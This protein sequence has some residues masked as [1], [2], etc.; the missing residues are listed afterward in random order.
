MPSKRIVAF[1]AIASLVVAGALLVVLDLGGGKNAVAAPAAATPK[2]KLP[3]RT[4]AVPAPSGGTRAE[5]VKAVKPGAVTKAST[6]EPARLPDDVTVEVVG[7]KSK[8]VK[9]VGPGESTSPAIVLDVKIANGSSAD[10]TVDSAIVALTYGKRADVG[11]PLTGGS[12][13]FTGTIKPGASARGTY[14]FG[15]PTAQQKS[16]Q[17]QVAYSAGAAVAQ[18]KGGVK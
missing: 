10:I 17:L 8:T 14:V 9:G 4:S 5:T 3:L 12:A 7:I 18:F 15:V 2:P 16:F 1:A 6:D 13:P 11:L